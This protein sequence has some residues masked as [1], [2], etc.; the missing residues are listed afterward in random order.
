M[1]LVFAATHDFAADGNFKLRV[2]GYVQADSRFFLSDSEQRGV[3]TL[4]LRRVRPIFESTMYSLY[5]VRIMPEYL[6]D[7]WQRLNATFADL[8]GEHAP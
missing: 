4:V 8:P 5:D 7:A 2:R 3:D 1:R 6:D